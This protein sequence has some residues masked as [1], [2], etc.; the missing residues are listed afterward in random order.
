MTLLTTINRKYQT[1][2]EDF[3]VQD[4]TAYNTQID[5]E[6]INASDS[7]K[8]TALN[9]NTYDGYE[10]AGYGEGTTT[11]G[12]TEQQAHDI[13]LTEFGNY[14]AI[15]KKQLLSKKIV[16]ISQ[17]VY[18]GLVLYHWATGNLFYSDAIEGK[19]SLSEHLLRENY[20]ILA[21]MIK[22]NTINNDKCI[23]ASTVLRLA[24]YGKNKNRTW[25]RTNGIHRMRDQNEKN[26]LDN[27]ELKRARFAY[28]AETGKFMPF[29]P[30]ST[31]RDI[32]KKYEATIVRQTFTYSG[33]KT[34]TLDKYFSMEP[35]EKLQVILNGEILDHLYDFTVS[36]L[37]ITITK[38]IKADDIVQTIIKI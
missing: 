17:S 31:K 21:D 4:T 10:G 7:C 1:V 24:D 12:L 32:V 18:D 5:L 16:K 19:Y 9:F 36:G 27:D 3:T 13:W 37:T 34:F 15:A 25:M 14:Q 8:L 38:A 33:T 22:R 26:L 6:T 20:D 29:T 28:Y 23:I 2:W 30:E 11:E 35:V